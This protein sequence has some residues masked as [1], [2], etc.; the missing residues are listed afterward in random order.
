[1]NLRK[2]AEDCDIKWLF[3]LRFKECPEYIIEMIVSKLDENNLEESKIK[4][5]WKENKIQIKDV[6]DLRDKLNKIISKL[7]ERDSEYYNRYY[8]LNEYNLIL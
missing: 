2:T 4:E 8:D 6:D 7:N 1:L 3:G 5:L